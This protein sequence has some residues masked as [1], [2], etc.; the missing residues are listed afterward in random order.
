[1]IRPPPR[2]TLFPYTTLFRS[3]C[4]V[5]G[6]AAA[7]LAGPPAVDVFEDLRLLLGGVT[8][9]GGRGKGEESEGDQEVAVHGWTSFTQLF[10]LYPIPVCC[11]PPLRRRSSCRRL[12]R[13]RSRSRR[14]VLRG[15]WPTRPP[16]WSC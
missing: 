9:D 11:S 6:A 1:M 8:G 5:R 4:A 10:R 16:A 13:L 7:D 3:E 14:R 2:S 15:A 12:P